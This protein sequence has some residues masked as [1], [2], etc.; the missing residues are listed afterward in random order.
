MALLF[1]RVKTF[2]KKYNQ[3]NRKQP[4]TMLNDQVAECEKLNEKE[5]EKDIYH[6]Q[7]IFLIK[8]LKIFVHHL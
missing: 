3:A 8:N 6:W 1:A 7:A 2:Y 4:L 5:S